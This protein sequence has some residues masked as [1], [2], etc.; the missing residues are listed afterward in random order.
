AYDT[1]LFETRATLPTFS[2][3]LLALA[4]KE[5]GDDPNMLA[6]LR[7]ELTAKVSLE[8]DRAFVRR[9]SD[10]WYYATMDSDVRTTALVL[11]ALQRLA[12]EDPLVDKLARGLLAERR[13]ARWLSTQDNGFAILALSEYF[14]RVERPGEKFVATVRLDGEVLLQ[15]PMV[16]GTFATESLSLAMPKLRAAAGKLLTVTREG[17]DDAPLYYALRFDYVPREVPTVAVE[18]GFGVDREYTFAEGPDI[19][20]PATS[21]KAGDLVQVKLT[22]RTAEPRR[23]VAIDD[24]LP[25]GLEPVETSF[26]TSSERV[27]VE[28]GSRW[29]FDHIEQHDDRVTLFANSMRAGRHTHTYLARATTAGEFIAPAARVHEMYQPDV[30]GQSTALAYSVQ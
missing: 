17:S 10:V 12:P 23:Y 22:V 15:A 21:V 26:E 1:R 19:G 2:L 8:G 27:A 20:K 18:H 5:A 14:K 24:L 11:M 25:A 29:V 30:F 7:G 16:G 4:A 9:T 28:S 6:T 13:G 3:A